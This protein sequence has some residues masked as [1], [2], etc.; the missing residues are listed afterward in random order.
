MKSVP[1][2]NQNAKLL[3]LK[4]QSEE[5]CKD[6]FKIYFDINFYRNYYNN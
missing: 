6:C 3:G 5:K 2:S 4:I 1:D